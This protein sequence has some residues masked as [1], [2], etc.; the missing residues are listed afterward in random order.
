MS[1]LRVQKGFT[2]IEL[3]VV[4]AIIGLLASIVLVSLNS[5]R[6]KARD[7]K[8]MSDLRQIQTA[9]EMYADDHN[10]QY[11]IRSGHTNSSGSHTSGWVSLE[12]DISPYLDSVPY[13]TTSGYS[14]YYDGGE[15]D[16]VPGYGLMARFE[17][18]G[19]Y[20]LVAEDNGYY[21]NVNNGA[22]WEIGPEPAYDKASGINW[23]GD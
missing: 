17:N 2:L 19:N 7:A 8:R 6:A 9:I 12:S 23:W 21:N 11:P 1:Q 18:S 14:Y 4:I 16:D 5:A 13:D 22:Y 15:S 3:L 20:H 10:G